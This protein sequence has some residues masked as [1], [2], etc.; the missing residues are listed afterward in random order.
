MKVVFKLCGKRH[1]EVS[2]RPVE[3]AAW[4][5]DESI[6]GADTASQRPLEYLFD[7]YVGV[8]SP[9]DSSTHASCKEP[10]N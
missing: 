10:R 2:V 3:G 1:G 8:R 4:N 5:A 9:H 6:D 7:L